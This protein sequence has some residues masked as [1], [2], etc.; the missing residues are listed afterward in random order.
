MR[1]HDLT[2]I[3]H[4]A[5]FRD[6]RQSSFDALMQAAYV[7]GFPQGLELIRQGDHA[8]FLHIIIDGAV[9]LYA[10]WAGRETTMAVVRPVGTFILAASIRDAP[11]LMAARTLERS[12]IVMVPSSDLRAVFREDS[13]F[14]VSVVEEL[15]GCYRTI[16]RHAKG[17]KLRSSRER[18]ASYLLRQSMIAGNVAG[19]ILPIEKRIL[20]SYLG[21]TPENLS[22]TLKVLEAD[23]VKIDGQRVIITDRARLTAVARPDALIDGPEPDDTGRGSTLP[24]VI[25]RS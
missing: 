7:Q 25:A 16:V 9:E 5:L 23:G 6:M 15:A 8:D 4:L 3:R 2:E 17:L 12:R 11:Y 24:P 13:G 14:A 10:S 19:F 22:R 21:M 18:I 20:A 1:P